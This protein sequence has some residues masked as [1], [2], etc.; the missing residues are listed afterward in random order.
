M[1]KMLEKKGLI[2]HRPGHTRA[3]QILVP[4]DEIPAW[5]GREPATTP[6][7]P[8]K[9]SGRVAAD[10]TTPPAKLYVISSS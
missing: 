5:N 1:V 4:E 7:H 3:L 2:L 8:D 9:S 10:P 6:E